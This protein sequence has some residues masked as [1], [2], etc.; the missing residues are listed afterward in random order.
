MLS[1]KIYN[2]GIEI[3]EEIIGQ[4]YTK[5][6]KE[7]YRQILNDLD[8][9][10]F[11]ES[12]NKLF[13]HYKYNSLPKPADIY[14]YSLKNE[15]EINEIYIK[16]K[17][18]ISE[19]VKSTN[20]AYIFDEPLTHKVITELGGLKR[21]GQMEIT[22]FD[23]CMNTDVKSIIKININKKIN[24]LDI[25]IGNVNSPIKIIGN[26]QNALKWL[27]NYTQK[28]KTTDEKILNKIKPLISQYINNK[29]ELIV[30]LD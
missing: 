7:L 25:I 18:H 13:R 22:A 8:D 11:I 9:K 10:K 4:K 1:D 29:Q 24:E 30:K 27:T 21:L 23:I 26:K 20:W 12:I 19:S 3:I 28:Y 14:Q 6:Q 5:K 15:D 2:K 17:M 16:I